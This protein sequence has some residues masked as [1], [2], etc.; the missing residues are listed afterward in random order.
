MLAQGKKRNK[1]IATRAQRAGEVRV[2]RGARGQAGHAHRV[3][4][5]RDARSPVV[6][7]ER[8]LRRPAAH[9]LMKEIEK[10]EGLCI[11]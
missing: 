5:V 8:K 10:S 2:D 4:A 11:Y 3:R 7:E 6:V 9:I 1:T